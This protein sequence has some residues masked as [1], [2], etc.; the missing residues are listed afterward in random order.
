[1]LKSLCKELYTTITTL[2][3]NDSQTGSGKIDHT[4]RM[5]GTYPEYF[6]DKLSKER[7]REIYP[8]GKYP[9]YSTFQGGKS[10]RFELILDFV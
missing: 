10:G 6:L 2:Y 3:Y 7:N 8:L 5:S 4:Y 1:M 9:K